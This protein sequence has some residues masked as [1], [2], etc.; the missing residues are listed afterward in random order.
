MRSPDP[1]L[2]C[3]SSSGPGPGPVAF[4][5]VQVCDIRRP[6]GSSSCGWYVNIAH[7]IRE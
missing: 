7:H 1:C 2:G 5:P 6:G 4:G 3:R